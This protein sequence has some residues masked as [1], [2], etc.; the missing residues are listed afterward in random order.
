VARVAVMGNEQGTENLGCATYIRVSRQRCFGPGFQLPLG[1]HSYSQ[2]PYIP[3]GPLTSHARPVS[4]M[5]SLSLA[6]A[7]GANASIASASAKTWLIL[8]I[9]APRPSQKALQSGLSL[10]L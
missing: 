10:S 7:P 2:S 9:A 8:L 3:P 6:N 1:A 4:Q 5:M